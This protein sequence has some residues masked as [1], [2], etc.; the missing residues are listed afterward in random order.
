MGKVL[1][2]AIIRS[3]IETSLDSYVLSLHALDS[4]ADRQWTVSPGSAGFES[5]AGFVSRRIRQ[6]GR[7][8]LSSMATILEYRSCSVSLAE[9]YHKARYGS[10]LLQHRRAP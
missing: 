6:A 3:Y 4:A 9:R 5:R 1:A 10:I 8:D 7:A 2:E